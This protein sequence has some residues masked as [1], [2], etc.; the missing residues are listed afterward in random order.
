[1]LFRSEPPKTFD[2][3]MSMAK[4]LTD[5]SKQVYGFVGRGVKNANVVL[6]DSILLGWDQE[7]VTPDGKK[8]LTDTPAAIEA[9][10]WYQQIMKQYGPPGNIGFNWNECQTTFMQGR[11]AMWWDGIGFSAPLL[12]KTKSKVVD[13][14]GF[15]PVPAGPK[16]H[17]CA[18]FIDGMGI[19]ATAKNKKAAWLWLQWI[20][21]KD[22]Q[23]EQLRTGVWYKVAGGDGVGNLGAPAPKSLADEFGH[24]RVGAQALGVKH[25][26]IALPA[27]CPQRNAAVGLR[28]SRPHGIG[29]PRLAGRSK[30]RRCNRSQSLKVRAEAVPIIRRLRPGNGNELHRRAARC[31]GNGSHDRLQGKQTEWSSTAR[32][33]ERFAGKRCRL[34][35][36]TSYCGTG[37]SFSRTQCACTTTAVKAWARVHALP[38]RP[39]SAGPAAVRAMPRRLCPW[40]HRPRVDRSWRDTCQR[41]RVTW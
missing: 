32:R 35:G 5:P 31:S 11:A 7:T 10:K 3:M 4:A 33:L 23:A 17:N 16:A 27:P 12:D 36:K 29:L 25:L 37:S 26:A 30:R 21:G 38:A 18:T 13:K 34:C 20:T 39:L 6:Y 22:M 40:P 24:Q 28:A 8:L 1:M 15:A 9:G 2:E 14:V 19:P 41:R